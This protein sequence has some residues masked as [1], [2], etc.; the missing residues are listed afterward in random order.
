L[1]KIKAKIVSGKAS[2]EERLAYY[3][4]LEAN[5]EERR[6]FI[7]YKNLFAVHSAV[8]GQQSVQQREQ[9][10]KAIWGKIDRQK[11][12]LWRRVISYA[13]VFIVAVSVGTIFSMLFLN[14]QNGAG[15]GIV[16]IASKAK[17]VNEF[18]LADG[19][20]VSLNAN[21]E[22]QILA[23][24]TSTI[25][26]GLKGEA[27]FDIVHNESR[28]FIVNAGDVQI[29]DRGTKFTVQSDLKNKK[30]TAVLWEGKID[31]GVNNDPEIHSLEPGQ[32][33]T[34]EQGKLTVGEVSENRA[35]SH[36]WMK[37]EFVFRKTR[38]EHI[39]RELE[40]WYGVSIEFK[41]EEAKGLPFTATISRSTDIKDL[42]EML[43]FS[44][45][46]QYK[47]KTGANGETLFTI[48]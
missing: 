6:E 19:S 18:T 1:D 17:S 44:T 24:N 8:K 21:S 34:Y 11:T 40:Q 32:T 9:Q 39:A 42:L 27:Y 23:D 30:V 2:E 20:V 16:T 29:I 3:Q 10:L 13:A 4:Q 28:Q 38:L 14:D 22:I 35:L 26:L 7:A 5:P 47:A 15:N 46:I 43:S 36:D 41:S 45:D 12:Q 31:V 33:F 25:E 37:G 48:E